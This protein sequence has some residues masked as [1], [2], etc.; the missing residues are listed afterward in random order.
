MFIGNPPSALQKRKV[1][2]NEILSISGALS[3]VTNCC[4]KLGINK[5]TGDL[6][7]RDINNTWQPVP[8]GGSSTL[9]QVNGTPNGD[10]SLLNLIAGTNI[11]LTDDGTGGVTVDATGGAADRFGIEDST[12]VQDR[13]MNMGVFKFDITGA[14]SAP[15][16]ILSLTNTSLDGV[17]MIIS[18][19]NGNGV[20]SQASGSGIGLYGYSGSN[21]GVQGTS[22]SN[23]GVFGFSNNSL[24]GEFQI[25]P[26]DTTSILPVVHIERGTQGVA[27]NGIGG[28]I[29]F[30][31]TETG[32]VSLSN[33][34]ISTWTDATHITRTSE[35]SITGVNS[36]TTQTLLS[37]SGAG[38]FTLTQGLQNFVDDAAAATG[39]IPING[40][41]RNGS[42]VQIRVS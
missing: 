42:V 35:F 29:D 32:A 39:G 12:G 13:S 40:L 14:I 5:L 1:N 22:S 21:K 10:Q 36:A 7:Y 23:S 2:N 41:Y 8:S 31:I 30:A 25:F 15:D 4:Y 27:V 38:I 24:G 20:Y 11:T 26:A 3:G 18:T 34:I 16:Q 19:R 9:L 33:Q 28:S 6:Y 17:G 37:I